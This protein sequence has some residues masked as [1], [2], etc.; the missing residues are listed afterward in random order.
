MYVRE[1]A[2]GLI[3]YCCY[4]EMVI[5]QEPWRAILTEKRG[6]TA[7]LVFFTVTWSI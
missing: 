7:R 4:T 6:S 2:N 5:V 1:I 3:S